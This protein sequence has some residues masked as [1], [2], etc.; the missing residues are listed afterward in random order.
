MMND[1]DDRMVLIGVQLCCVTP[2]LVKAGTS[3]KICDVYRESRALRPIDSKSRALRPF[4]FVGPL[5][6]LRPSIYE[7]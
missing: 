2:G 7:I 5:R 1:D 3:V 4:D 6:A